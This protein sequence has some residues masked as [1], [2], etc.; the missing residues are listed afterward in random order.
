MA[1]PIHRVNIR[2]TLRISRR[3]LRAPSHLQSSGFFSRDPDEDSWHV[4]KAP[5]VVK[6]LYLAYAHRQVLPAI[7][8]KL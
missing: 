7:D 6:V 1:T 8:L 2:I 3:R 5:W 4:L